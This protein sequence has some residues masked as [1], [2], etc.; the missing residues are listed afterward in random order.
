MSRPVRG[1]AA[2]AVAWAVL[3]GGG[4]SAAGWQ[5]VPS[6]SPNQYK[7]FLIGVARVPGTGQLWAAGYTLDQVGPDHSLIERSTGGAFTVS[8]IPRAGRFEQLSGVSAASTSAAWAVGGSFVHGSLPL[9][10]VW[11]G[12][13]WRR[14]PVPLPPA[15][16]GGSLISVRA[17]SATDVTAVGTWFGTTV[18]GGPLIE[19]WDGHAWSASTAP[20]P[21]GCQATFTA[22]AAVPGSS[23]RFAVGF[24]LN[25]DGTS[26]QAV[27]ERLTGAGWSIVPA[28][29]PARSSLQS[30]TPVSGKELWAV[31]S[32]TT[33]SGAERTL[34]ERWNGSAWSVVP[35][36]N[37]TAND[38]LRSV[39]RV[40]GT[41]TLW[42][43]GSAVNATGSAGVAMRWN[44]AAWRSVPPAQ[45]SHGVSLGGVAAAPG[46]IWAVGDV[47]PDSPGGG[48]IARTLAEHTPG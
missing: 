20:N 25:A 26:T 13:A 34:A 35:T 41:A 27:I 18:P 9:V 38:A 42:A 14:T 29:A 22:V 43:V 15:A 7:N 12:S 45:P 16:A 24:C 46:G 28:H 44:G 4:A 17:F 39:I 19:H 36:P 31:G 23:G 40:P 1:F 32:S 2:A 3:F 30:V 5:V 8:P 21:A 6:A 37:P 10:F 11:N 47:F 33:M 48:P